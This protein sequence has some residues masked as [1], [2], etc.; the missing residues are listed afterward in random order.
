MISCHPRNNSA[1]C[2][3]DSRPWADGTPCGDKRYYWCRRGQCVP[4][5]YN[6]PV[7]HGEWGEWQPYDLKLFSVSNEHLSKQFAYICFHF[8]NSF[9]ACSRTCGG[10]IRESLRECNNPEPSETGEYCRGKSVRYESCN[11]QECPEGTPDFRAKQ[12]KDHDTDTLS[13][14]VFPRLRKFSPQFRLHV[15]IGIHLSSQSFPKVTN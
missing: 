9:G 15:N 3:S 5:T 14:T 1:R 6:I 10:G 11:T 2:R 8:G 7:V 13:W 4:K 12:C